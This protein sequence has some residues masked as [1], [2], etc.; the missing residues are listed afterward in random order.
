MISD[1]DKQQYI[2]MLRGHDWF[3]EH[4]DDRGAYNK[5]RAQR[6]TLLAMRRHLDADGAIWNATAPADCRL[7]V[8]AC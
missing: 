1:T 8:S 2:A 3:Y 6:Q 4:S 7:T 5:G